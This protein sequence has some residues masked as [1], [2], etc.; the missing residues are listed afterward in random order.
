MHNHLHFGLFGPSNSVRE[1]V[2]STLGLGQKVRIEIILVLDFED[3]KKTLDI[4][5]V[6]KALK[7]IFYQPTN[8]LRQIKTSKLDRKGDSRVLDRLHRGR[9]A[10]IQGRNKNNE[11][12]H[13]FLNLRLTLVK[14]H[15]W[16]KWRATSVAA[17][18]WTAADKSRHGM[19][20]TL[21][22]SMLSWERKKRVK[23][24]DPGVQA[25]RASVREGKWREQHTDETN[26]R[27]SLDPKVC[28]YRDNI[29]S[30]GLSSWT[31]SFLMKLL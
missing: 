28:C 1:Q 12:K 10:H 15:L 23:A 13:I 6:I 26:E 25:L 5:G 20:G 3:L 2:S 18:P 27:N 21:A 4:K 16:I 8:D 7:N 22:L 14:F 17:L 9:R 31:Q 24:C 19:R 11:P 30:K 29:P